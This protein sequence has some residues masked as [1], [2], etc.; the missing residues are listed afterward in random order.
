MTTE[1]GK[2]LKQCPTALSNKMRTLGLLK[3]ALNNKMPQYRVLQVA[4]ELGI[5]DAIRHSNPISADDRLRIT[6]G[7]V[8]QY[9]M[10]ESAAKKAIEYW[11]NSVDSDILSRSL[12]DSEISSDSISPIPAPPMQ[13]A[14]MEPSVP[15]QSC[16]T[17]KITAISQ[18]SIRLGIRLQWEKQST[19][20]HYELWRA[21]NAEPP[22][23]IKEGTFPI[24][25][26]Q[27][28]DVEANALYTYALRGTD[29]AGKDIARS[30]DLQL[31][32]PSKPPIFQIREIQFMLSGIQI[33]WSMI[34]EAEKYQIQKNSNGTGWQTVAELPMTQTMYLDTAIRDGEAVQYKIQCICKNNTLLETTAIEVNL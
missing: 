3:D 24:P 13:P 4:Y 19:I 12:N 33:K 5:V 31:V 26:Y 8:S 22:V 29:E 10:L 32:A 34:F 17:I 28:C 30:P 27:D 9:A 18:D 16:S 15:N 6:T 1:F 21:K 2:Y 25:R 20:S 23:K 11:E 14:P 7:L